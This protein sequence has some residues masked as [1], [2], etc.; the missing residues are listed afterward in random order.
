MKRNIKVKEIKP[1]SLISLF[2]GELKKKSFK[3][4]KNKVKKTGLKKRKIEDSSSDNSLA[5][6]LS[7]KQ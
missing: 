3:E 5:S 6:F 4:S 7:E 1:E 2:G